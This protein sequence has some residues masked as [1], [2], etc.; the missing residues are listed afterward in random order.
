MDELPDFHGRLEKF[1]NYRP[2]LTKLVSRWNEAA[3]TTDTC[4]RSYAAIA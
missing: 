1:L 4:S 3:R 2:H